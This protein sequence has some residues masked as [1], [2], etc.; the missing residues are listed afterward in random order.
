[1]SNP[2]DWFKIDGIPGINKGVKKQFEDKI[3]NQ[4]IFIEGQTGSGKSITTPWYILNLIENCEI[5][6]L[7]PRVNIVE[8][9]GNKLNEILVAFEDGNIDETKTFFFN[10]TDELN[11][12]INYAHGSEPKEEPTNDE[13]QF[14]SN[15]EESNIKVMTLGYYKGRVKRLIT[16]TTKEYVVIIDEAHEK[17]VDLE[18]ILIQL[19]YLRQD[20]DIKIKIII[21]SATLDK[22]DIEN[23]KKLFELTNC[24]SIKIESDGIKYHIKEHFLKSPTPN[25]EETILSLIQT[26]YDKKKK[27][28]KEK[29][30]KV[31]V[32]LTG[33]GQ[34]NRMSTECEK[35]SLGR[36]R[37]RK[38]YRGVDKIK[39]EKEKKD[40]R[41]R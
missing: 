30:F 41:R 11:I 9:I 33:P 37:I 29:E 10:N 23:Y 27:Y 38:F 40:N 25:Y 31:L 36:T 8:S 21:M 20:Y 7:Q 35:L 34:I 3:N 26:L 32:F 39:K 18:F 14:E 4:L 28:N 6:F 13:R 22:E 15:F 16:D 17:N 1:M 24:G 12:S 19:K 2:E 5:H